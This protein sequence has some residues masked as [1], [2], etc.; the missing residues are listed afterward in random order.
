N[1]TSDPINVTNTAATALSG[2]VSGAGMLTK[3]GSGALILSN[4]ASTS[5]GLTFV[6][7]G[8]IQVQGAA[9]LGGTTAAAV[10][11]SGAA[12]QVLGSGL[13]VAKPII[14][15]GTG[16]NGGGALENLIG[17]GNTWS[18]AVT[19]QSDSSIGADAG[20]T[21]TDTGVIGGVANLTKAGVGTVVF[22]AASTFTG[23]TTVANGV[24]NV[25]SAGGLGLVTG[26]IS[27][28]SG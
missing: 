9:A 4:N 8:V 28:S 20:T 7:Q 26:S 11:A 22:N 14:L 13:T 23:N 12:V 15:N 10:V 24:A 21:L 27:V 1:G 3:A 17:G 6:N 18:G 16:V 5:T 25:Q 2:V 19:L